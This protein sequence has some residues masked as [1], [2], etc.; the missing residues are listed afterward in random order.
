VS[1]T[2]YQKNGVT[3]RREVRSFHYKDFDK[4]LISLL[5]GGNMP[6][7]KLK[8]KKKK[9]KEKD[10]AN[11]FIGRGEH[12]G[13]VTTPTPISTEPKAKKEKPKCTCVGVHCP[14]CDKIVEMEISEGRYKTQISNKQISGKAINPDFPCPFCNRRLEMPKV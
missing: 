8:K 12:A 9:K 11:I 13:P 14:T 3:F 10:L 1:V 5:E 6:E 2:Y 7:E 4:E